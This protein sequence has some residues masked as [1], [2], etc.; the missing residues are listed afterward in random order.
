LANRK[1]RIIWTPKSSGRKPLDQEAINIIIELK[2]LNPKWGAQKISDEL[3]KVGYFACKKTVLKYLEING[4]SS[5]TIRS[6]PSWSEF[7]NNHKFKIGIDF[8]SLISL[9]GHQLFIFVII[10]LDSRKLIHINVTLNPCSEWIKQQFRN[11]FLDTDDYPTLCI[12][13]NDQIFKRWFED[14]LM[15]YFGMKLK[16][17]PYKSPH[18]N[19]ITERFNLSLKVEAF[20]NVVPINVYQSQRICRMF[21]DYYNFY[22]P[23]Q[24]IKGNIPCNI[25][26]KL[27]SRIKFVK[28]DHLGGKIISLESQFGIGA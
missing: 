20:E 5:P 9:M 13:D 16:R 10:N 6:G 23:H 15:N 4:L 22:R 1:L 11:A 27:C 7:L 8:T 18:K 28:K 25:T 19:G 26:K 24:G 21:Q 12:C 17:T 14:M 3:N 2:T